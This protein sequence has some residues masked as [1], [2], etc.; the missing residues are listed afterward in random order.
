VLRV[1]VKDYTHDVPKL[2]VLLKTH[3]VLCLIPLV[4]PKSCDR[5]S[6][7]ASKLHFPVD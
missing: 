4:P 6:S 5:V 2:F 7:V 3:K 1:N